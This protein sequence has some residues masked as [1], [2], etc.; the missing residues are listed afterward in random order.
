MKLFIIGVLLLLFCGLKEGNTHPFYVS[1]CQINHNEQ[2][3]SL[4]ISVK[5]FA[6]DL[7]TAL[8]ERN[9][10]NLFLGESREIPQSD[11]YISEY[12]NDNISISPNGKPREF[13]FIGK[14]L[15]DDAIWCYLE[16]KDV[17][18]LNNIEVKDTILTEIFATQN[19]IV[20]VTSKGK[21]KN[22]LLRK[23]KISGSLIF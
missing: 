6:D 11:Q 12:L 20:Q 8:Y 18:I 1:I 15:E 14:E 19:N 9:I 7:Q 4:E 16:I 10:E 22:L 5:I 23:D 17:D 2:N 3:H 21:T 13:S